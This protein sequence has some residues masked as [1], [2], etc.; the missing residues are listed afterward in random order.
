MP[1]PLAN[2][3][4]LEPEDQAYVEAYQCLNAARSYNMG[5]PNPLAVTEMTTY[6]RDLTTVDMLSQRKRFV[7]FMQV[8]DEVVLAHHADK[9]EAARKAKLE[10]QSKGPKQPAR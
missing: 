9:A 10:A 2:R 1:A 6:L 5:G 4:K 7:R 8:M 3:P